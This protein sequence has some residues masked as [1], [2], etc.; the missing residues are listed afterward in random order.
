MRVILMAGLLAAASIGMA[1]AQ[2]VAMTG[3]MGS[4]A[5]LIVDG[6]APKA[7]AAGETHRGVKVVSVSGGQAVVEVGGQRQVL[8]IG[9]GPVA[10]KGAGGGS[11][12]GTRIV[13]TAGTG[14][15][16]LSAGQ[17]NGRAVQFMV[18][19]GAT[20]VSIGRAEAD[21]LG[22]KY[23]DGQPIML[24]TANG[25]AQGW[26]VSLGSV[27]I[28]DVEVHGVEAT[29]TPQ[30]MPFVLL[31]NSFLTRFQMKRENDTLMLDRRY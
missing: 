10:F 25:L 23:Q 7:V 1:H 22:I 26:R 4:R 6:G 12:A 17:I 15:H 24:S 3:A 5:L 31:G 9:S 19:T 21:R 16:F 13:L 2:S 14:G 18:D 29:V 8:A 20:S 30:S 28:Q 27:R 11:G